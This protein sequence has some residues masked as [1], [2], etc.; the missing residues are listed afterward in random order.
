MAE[1]PLDREA[2]INVDIKP[3]NL[4]KRICYSAGFINAFRVSPDVDLAGEANGW[5]TWG[6]DLEK[7][8]VQ[9]RTFTCA[10]KRSEL[11]RMNPCS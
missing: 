3:I 5:V 4:L 8:S 6:I 10:E 1:L 11:G 9:T 2:L 7:F